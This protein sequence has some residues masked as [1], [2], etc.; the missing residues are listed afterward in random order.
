MGTGIVS[1]LIHN[2]P[3][4]AP[5]L[6]YIADIFFALNTALFVVFTG[7]TVLRYSLYPEIWSVMVRHP[8]QSLFLGSYPM[9]LSSE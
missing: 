6:S 7:I 2:L 1:I 8:A 5:W 9:G 3:Y 4:T